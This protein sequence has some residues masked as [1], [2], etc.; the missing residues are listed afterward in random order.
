MLAKVTPR[1]FKNIRIPERTAGISTVDPDPLCS[2]VYSIS[3]RIILLWINHLYE[4]HRE[5]I[6]QSSQK[7]RI[8]INMYLIHN[9]YLTFIYVVKHNYCQ[10]IYCFR[11]DFRWCA[12]LSMGCE[13]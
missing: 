4:Q 8:N 6:W 1:Q 7:G 13:L 9:F 3:E 11:Y 12:P 5:R 2:N 10:T